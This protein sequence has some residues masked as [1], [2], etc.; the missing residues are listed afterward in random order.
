MLNEGIKYLK[1]LPPPLG[2]LLKRCF[3][4][5]RYWRSLKAARAA[6][7]Q[8]GQ[9]YQYPVLFI[10]GMPKSGTTWLEKMIASYPGYT[11]LLIPEATF[12]ELANG[13]G[14]IFELP[15]NFHQRLHKAL[16]VLKMHCD[17]SQNNVQRL[18]EAVYPYVVLYRDPRDVAISHYHY[19]K[20]TPWHGDYP[21]IK[22]LDLE[23]GI[24]YFI[25]K[26]LPEFAH[27]MRS[28]RDHRDHEKSLMISYEELRGD[29]KDVL[30]RVFDLFELPATDERISEIVEANTIEAL[31]KRE[32]GVSNFYR[33]GKSGGWVKHF[34]PELKAAF[35]AVDTKLLIE[36]DYEKDDSW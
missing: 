18:S 22:D 23:Q 12:A 5:P 21:V 13:Q 15:E 11:E 17:G 33:E 26:R 10:A 32:A 34:T 1:V 20:D 27:W 3:V 19:V 4:Y 24:E 7:Q 16:V 28:W 31:R 29:A 14:H 8:H 6:F 25:R 9:S 35:K 2:R 36:F 30:R